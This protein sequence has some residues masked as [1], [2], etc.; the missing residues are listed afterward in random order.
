MDRGPEL[1]SCEE[2]LRELDHSLKEVKRQ[3]N[4]FLYL[5]GSYKDGGAKISL[6]W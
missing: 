2:R 4:S 6:E 5:K 1:V 3:S